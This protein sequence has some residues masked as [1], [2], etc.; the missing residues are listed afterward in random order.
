LSDQGLAALPEEH[1]QQV[2][3]TAQDVLIRMTDT[4]A[5]NSLYRATAKHPDWHGRSMLL[6]VINTRVSTD[7]R[8]HKAVIASLTDST[9]AVGWDG[10][11]VPAGVHKGMVPGQ[12]R[13]DKDQAVMV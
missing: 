1:L 7:A 6:D 13:H 5:W 2:W 12:Y 3:T 11:S 4:Q 10:E 9:D 8:A